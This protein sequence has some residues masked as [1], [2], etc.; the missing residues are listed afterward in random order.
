MVDRD[1]VIKSLG[2]TNE[3]IEAILK[4]N[5][6][7]EKSYEKSNEADKKKDREF[8]LQ[9]FE[10]QRAY[11]T[12]NSILTVVMAVSYSY[13]VATITIGLTVNLPMFTQIGLFAVGIVAISIGALSSYLLIRH[14][15][16]IPDKLANIRKQFI[17]NNEQKDKQ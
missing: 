6:T 2:K 15:K 8:Q 5:A 17:E 7:I 4:I 1:E 10:V 12:L 14:H 3:E 9:L 16:S 11:D 13:V